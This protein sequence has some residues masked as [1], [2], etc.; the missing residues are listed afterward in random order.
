M[1]LPNF[2]Q[3]EISD[4]KLL[5]YLLDADHPQSKGKAAFYALVGYTKQNAPLLRGELLQLVRQYEV[6]NVI[7]TDFGRRYVVEGWLSCPNGKAYPLRTVWFI[8]NG[9]IIPKLVTADP[10][11]DDND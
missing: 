7:D 2:D 10:N 9:E 1:K 5:T 6:V 11:R 4:R 3:A 8:N